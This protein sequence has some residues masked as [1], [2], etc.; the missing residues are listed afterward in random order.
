M[1][2]PARCVTWY[3]SEMQDRAQYKFDLQSELRQALENGEIITWYQPQLSLQTGKIAG[4]ENPWM[5]VT[6]GGWVNPL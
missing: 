2:Q 6:S 4:E 3:H 1:R 5:V